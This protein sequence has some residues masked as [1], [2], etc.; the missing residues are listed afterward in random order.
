MKSAVIEKQNTVT[1][2]KA[3]TIDYIG[4]IDRAK[5]A[6][7]SN[8]YQIGKY[9]KSIKEDE[10]Y[11]KNGIEKF[12]E[13]LKDPR[14]DFNPRYA[15]YLIKLTA[16]DEYKDLLA[17]GINKLLA[18]M[19]L[20]PEQQKAFLEKFKYEKKKKLKEIS[21]QQ[22]KQ[23]LKEQKL[24]G[25]IRCDRCKKLVETAKEIDGKFYGAGGKHSCYDKEMEERRHLLNGQIPA[26]VIDNVLSVL[27]KARPTRSTKSEA[28]VAINWLPD[29]IY[30][31][32]AQLLKESSK[33]NSPPV[34]LK[35]EAD[36][37]S[38]LIKILK[39]RMTDVQ[40]AL[41]NMENVSKQ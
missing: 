2:P 30:R 27:K 9:L 13:I 6:I 36:S 21:L 17:I 29:T 22:L 8:F 18:I 23:L 20:T 37:L 24:K 5:E 39:T 19:E 16:Q 38:K 1:E 26:P 28:E 4:K 34:I 7:A 33:Q 3:D 35:N 14:L 31:L 11:K 40:T 25:K 12:Q 15:S 32:Y 10:I 41:T